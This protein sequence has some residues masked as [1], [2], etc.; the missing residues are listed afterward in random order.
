M[1]GWIKTHR[2]I[3]EWEW[4]KKPFMF[5]LFSHLLLKANH[6]DKR[7]QGIEVKRGQLITSRKSLSF[8]TGIPEQTTRTCLNRLKSTNELTIRSTKHYSLITIVNF[9][10]YQSK[11]KNQPTDQPTDA[12]AINQQPT[13]DQPTTNHKQEWEEWKEVYSDKSILDFSEKFIE[14]SEKEHG[15]Q[16][17]EQTLSLLK[18]SC[19]SV[20]KLIRLDGNTLER[21]TAVLRW[22]AKDDFWSTQLRSLAGLRKKNGDGLTKFQNIA[23]GYNGKDKTPPNKFKKPAGSIDTGLYNEL[24]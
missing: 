2:S 11:E 16:A 23:A 15:N 22:A 8:Q 19:D 24:P 1:Q 3:T 7:W 6:S 9:E 21:I 20:D 14:W 18:N 13:N 17:P 5:H 10:L 4:Y 12:P